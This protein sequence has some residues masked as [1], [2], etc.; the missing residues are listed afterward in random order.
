MKT[1][2]KSVFWLIML[3][4]IVVSSLLIAAVII[5]LSTSV[6]LPL[7]AFYEVIILSYFLSLCYLVLYLAKKYYALQVYLQ[8]IFDLFSITVLVYIAGGLAGALYILYVL[9]IIAA[10]LILSGR[11]S[12][13][14]AAFSA[15]LFGLLADGLFYGLIP[16]FRLE[17]ARELSPGVVLYTVF[18]AWGLFFIIA[19]LMNSLRKNLQKTKEALL[20]AQK[21][22]EIKERQATAG[23]TAAQI[24]HEIR[25]PLAAIVGSVQFL[26]SELPLDEKQ[27][28][29]VNIILKESERVSQSLEQFLDLASPRKQDFSVFDISTVFKETLA[30]FERSGEIDGR[31]SFRGNYALSPISYYGNSDQFKQIFWNILRNSIKAMPQG[32][33]LDI[34]FYQKKKSVILRFAD[35][36]SGMSDEEAKKIFEPFYS[37]F[38][39]GRGLGLTIV[40]NIVADYE[41]DIQV[42]SA[43]GEGTEIRIAL[44]LRA[45]KMLTTQM[46]K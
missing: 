36:G 10:S 40:R 26:R 1:D 15:I 39:N 11:A 14:I 35:S 18:M 2:Q 7:G 33:T 6:F 42:H 38:T 8:L 37:G 24:A 45:K 41:G 28:N 3:R 21:E 30:L 25:N 27:K 29:L 16:Y 19:A 12:F 17:Q 22:L 9:P 4:L 23:R 34:D 5:Q 46:R 20:L 32:G 31:Y 43:P 13:L 44:P